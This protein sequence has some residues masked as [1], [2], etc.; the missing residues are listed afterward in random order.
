MHEV[1]EPQMLHYA[2]KAIQPGIDYFKSQMEGALKHTPLAC[3]AACLFYP[4]KVHTM[5]PRAADLDVHKAFPFLNTEI[6]D[7]LKEE[8]PVY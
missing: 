6:I 7:K 5:K 8:L 2:Q 1:S 4:Q 3:K